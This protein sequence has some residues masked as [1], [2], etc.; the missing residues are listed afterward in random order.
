MDA[1]V[2]LMVVCL[3]WCLFDGFRMERKIK[4]LTAENENFRQMV[5]LGGAAVSKQP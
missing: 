5:G 1:L 2:Y 4:A 3:V